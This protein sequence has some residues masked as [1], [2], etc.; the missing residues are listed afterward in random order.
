MAANLVNGH[1]MN[2]RAEEINFHV[3][4]SRW[5]CKTFRPA[6]LSPLDATALSR[7]SCQQHKNYMDRKQELLML[8]LRAQFSREY[9]SPEAIL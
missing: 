7:Q 3:T 8:H 1:S 2:T 5:G 9:S 6:N 4:K